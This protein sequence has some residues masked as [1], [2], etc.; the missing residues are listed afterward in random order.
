MRSLLVRQVVAMM[1]ALRTTSRLYSA[2]RRAGQ[3]R[4][5]HR[6][7]M[8]TAGMSAARTAVR[9]SPGT[10]GPGSDLELGQLLGA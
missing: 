8:A 1:S 7:A 9:R 6:N 4:R 2:M 5:P 10:E 3:A